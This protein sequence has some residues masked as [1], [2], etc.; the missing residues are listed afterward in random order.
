MI[1]VIQCA[2]K[3]RDDA[4]H[5]RTK[6]G[7]RVL[8]V[9]DPDRAPPKAG[10]VYARPDDIADDG[11]AWR[12]IL[13]GYNSQ[14]GNNPLGLL[15]AFELYANDAYRHLADRVGLDKM[16]ILSA[17]WGLINAAFLTPCYDI[18]FS[19]QAEPYKRRRKTDHY[20][21]L[22]MLPRETNEPIVFFGGKDYLPLFRELT[23]GAWSPRTVFF[24]S[25][26]VPQIQGGSAVRFQTTT[27]TNWHYECVNAFLRGEI[28]SELS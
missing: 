17:G 27:R 10:Y 4:G 3:K 18:T 2:A 20:R 6:D 1:V 14:P 24:N 5:L 9:A 19:A 7:R 23:D 21:D 13:Q 15:R 12:D 11:K 8:F 28:G 22:R 25:A 26:T 16:F